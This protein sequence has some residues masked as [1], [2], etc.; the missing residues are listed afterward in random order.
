MNE[1]GLPAIAAVVAQK[2][3]VPVSHLTE[4]S[5]SSDNVYARRVFCLSAYQSGY[6]YTSIGRYLRRDHTTVIHAVKMGRA[7]VQIRD[8]SGEVHALIAKTIPEM[9]WEMRSN[10]RYMPIYEKYGGKCAV[11]SFDEVVEIH[12]IVPKR[13]HGTDD[14]ENLILLCPNH[15]AMADRGMLFIKDINGLNPQSTCPQP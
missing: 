5:R 1:V 2:L 4:R 9:K 3:S 13:A 10:N 6:S 15:H 8:V 11:C 12:H 14:P 7:D